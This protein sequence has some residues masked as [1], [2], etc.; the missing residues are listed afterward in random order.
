LT[1]VRLKELASLVQAGDLEDLNFVVSKW[2]LKY[3]DVRVDNTPLLHLAVSSNQF[4]MVK[5]LLS[6]DV[7]IDALDQVH[8]YQIDNSDDLHLSLLTKI[9][10]HFRTV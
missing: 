2:H 7:D 3:R 4:S 8:Q 6:Q 10:S 9:F 5:F 1:L